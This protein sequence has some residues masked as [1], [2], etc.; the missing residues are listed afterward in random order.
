MARPSMAQHLQRETRN[1]N[2]K[3]IRIGCGQITWKNVEE[4]V[5]LAEIALA[6]YD[7]APA[8]PRPD[9]RAEETLALFAE[10]DLRPAPGYLGADFWRADQEEAI[11]SRAQSHADFAVAMGCTEVYVAAG[12]F[13]NYVTSRGLTRRQVSGHVHPDDAM[14]EDEYRQ[15]AKVLNQTG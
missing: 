6:G 8:G 5:V 4:R 2:M 1:V 13:D 12:G 14:S 11:L 15:F 10:F 9:R 7:G 3:P